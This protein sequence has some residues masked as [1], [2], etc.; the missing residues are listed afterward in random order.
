MVSF[1]LWGGLQGPLPVSPL[2]L[3]NS[4]SIKRP[5]IP[6]KKFLQKI[7]LKID[8]TILNSAFIF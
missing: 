3:A 2:K 6:Q 7:F 5:I 8:F 4:Y 1:V